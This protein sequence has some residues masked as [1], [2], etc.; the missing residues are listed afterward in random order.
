MRKRWLVVSIVL[1]FLIIVFVISKNIRIPQE[2]LV[3]QAFEHSQAKVLLASISC[4]GAVSKKFVD[5][6]KT[7]GLQFEKVGRIILNRYDVEEGSVES[8]WGEGQQY[9]EYRLTAKTTEAQYI[10]ILI[11]TQQLKE[12]EESQGARIKMEVSQDIC[13]ENFLKT[14]E[15]I[16][17]ALA[18]CA[19]GL[20][21]E[22]KITGTLDGAM[23]AD[24][25][26]QVCS[27]IFNKTRIK[28]IYREKQEGSINVFGYSPSWQQGLV[29]QDKKA[30]VQLE[31]KYS[32]YE[33]KTYIT[34]K[35]K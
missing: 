1:T 26:N 15:R 23:D 11:F 12:S 22:S 29:Q 21:F 5:Y 18:V 20:I 32:P 31:M 9:S 3:V 13:F 33:N 4:E 17:D 6:D 34:I 14:K 19:I 27:N 28:G 7:S 25:I 30:D 8:S 10:Q 24:E 35:S 16:A 2:E